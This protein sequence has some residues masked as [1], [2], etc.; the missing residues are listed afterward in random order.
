MVS[1][2]R[3]SEVSVGIV[4]EIPDDDRQ[5]GDEAASIGVGPSMAGSMW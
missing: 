1:V 5:R 3:Y 4:G 2:V